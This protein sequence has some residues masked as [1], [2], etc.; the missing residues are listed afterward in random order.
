ILVDGAVSVID[1]ETNTVIAKIQVGQQPL[2]AAVTPD[3]SRLYV[4]NKLSASVSV[5][6]TST[7]TVIHTITEGL[8]RGPSG[9][10]ITPGGAQLY[11]AHNNSQHGAPPH[12]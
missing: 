4:V 2:G 8:G 12:T 3:G 11:V 5:I 1:T 6:D 10:A 9:A 7:N